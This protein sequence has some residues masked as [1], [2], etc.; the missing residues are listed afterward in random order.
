M[1]ATINKSDILHDA[2]L[3]GID[4]GMITTAIVEIGSPTMRPRSY[5]GLPVSA[6][7][8]KNDIYGA[9]GYIDS[10]SEFAYYESIFVVEDS[11]GRSGKKEAAYG[12]GAVNA[13]TTAI[14]Q[15]LEENRA[16]YHLRKAG[17]RGNKKLSKELVREAYGVKLSNQHEVDA[18]MAAIRE[19]TII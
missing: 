19:I 5:K 16:T 7:S 10:I 13:I 3:V 2:R 15:I 9:L 11:R 4:P 14:V 12:A 1:K 6:N 8:Y 17:G 18:F